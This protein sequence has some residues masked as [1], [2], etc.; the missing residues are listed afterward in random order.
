VALDALVCS[1]AV[2]VSAPA[3]SAGNVSCEGLLSGPVTGDVIV[4]K[5]AE[6]ALEFADVSGNVI[7]QIDAT[8]SILGS[9]VGGNYTCNNC[10][11]SHLESSTIEGNYHVSHETEFSVITGST[12]EGNLQINA[13]RTDLVLFFIDTTEIG[14]NLLFNDNEGLAIIADNTTSGNLICQNNEP[15]PLSI[16]N[17]PKS[18]KGQCTA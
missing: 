12:I 5:G 9:T 8:V 11:Q 3:P 2:L 4:P 7:A 18:M 6:R 1:A 16:G 14:G 17:T 13:S 15:A 10:E